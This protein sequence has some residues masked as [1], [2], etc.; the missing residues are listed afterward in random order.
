MENQFQLPETRCVVTNDGLTVGVQSLRRALDD[1]L[2]MVARVKG[3]PVGVCLFKLEPLTGA[4]GHWTP[5]ESNAENTAMDKAYRSFSDGVVLQARVHCEALL[6]AAGILTYL[7]RTA[8]DLENYNVIVH[9]HYYRNRETPDGGFHKDTRG[10]TLFFLL[11]YL[12]EKPIYGAEWIRQ[13][14]EL[15]GVV[16]P[17]D[18]GPDRPDE[19]RVGPADVT[20]VWPEAI[21]KAVLAK[22]LQYE[23]EDDDIHVLRVD[24]YGAVLVV[25]DVIHHRTPNAKTRSEWEKLESVLYAKNADNEAGDYEIK[26]GRS[27]VRGEPGKRSS[28]RSMSNERKKKEEGDADV[29]ARWN[30]TFN[31]TRQ[32]FRIW[33]TVSPANGKV[34]Y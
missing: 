34:R 10:Q 26:R 16:Y 28:S 24:K 5:T 19:R 14:G 7:H 30:A 33:V 9:L 4:L 27:R 8:T 25:D 22:R 31:C 13:R 29:V 32:F 1:E 11:H 2:Q 20:Y 23:E 12:N 18:G 15:V 17:N 21:R 3:D 6:K